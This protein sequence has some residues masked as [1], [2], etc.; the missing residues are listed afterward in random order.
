MRL[1][2]LAR[3]W[4]AIAALC[5]I[6]TVGIGQ[7]SPRNSFSKKE[8]GV[9]F[10]LHPGILEV[11]VCS[12]SM[13]H[14]L[15]ILQEPVPPPTVP[16]IIDKDRSNP[17]PFKIVEGNGIVSVSTA[18]LTVAVELANGRITFLDRNDSVILQE[19]DSSGKTLAPAV[20]GGETLWRPEQKFLSPPDEAFY[21]L[22]Q[23][24]EGFF[25]WR[26]IPL[27]LQ[28]VD[29]NI[30]M[31]FVLSSKGYGLLWNSA[32]LTDFNP[33]DEV[34]QIDSVTKS[35]KFRS[36]ESGVYGFM[37]TGG[38]GREH[39]GL[40]V[41]GE[42]VVALDGYLVPYSGSGILNLQPNTDYTLTME[43]ASEGAKVYVRPPSDTTGFRSEVGKTIDY[44]FFYGPNLNEVIKQYRD[45]TGVAPMFP[46]WAYGFWQCRE[47][48]SSQDQLL[49]AAAG[50]RQ[51]HIPVDV[52]VQDWQYWGKFGWNAMKFDPD[53]YP[54]PAGMIHT[55][56]SENLHFAISVW[57][58]FDSQTDIYKQMKARSLLVPGSEWFDAF[59]PQ[60]R[61]LFWSSMRE[62]LFQLGVDGWWLDAT[63]PEG[64]ILKNNQTFMGP[65]NALRNAYPLYVT[66]AVFQGQRETAAA[67]RVVILTRSAFP[68][69][70]RNAT[71]VWSGDIAGDWETF[72]RQVSAGLNFT[73]TG[74]PYWTT[75][76]GGFNRPTDQ[77]KS[78]AYHEL[79]T[80]WFEYGI[81]C[82][83]FRIHGDQSETEIWNY[84][85]DVE[86]TFRK[87]DVFHYRLLPYIYSSAWMITSQGTT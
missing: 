73:M 79:L 51:R 28:Q 16:I 86:D 71:A 11:R 65:G 8:D 1:N 3:S 33:T 43:G 12:E 49:K 17:V 34:V 81:F 53:H 27:R 38:T 20:V 52:M 26:G 7:D 41:N 64:D 30:A 48:Y 55:L 74:M 36:V 13:V 59:N 32:A 37:V 56:H 67:K 39:L 24:Q 57:S 76:V 25:N 68:G 54:N 44:Y 35:G 42:S 4:L 77:Y 2:R 50:F 23:H 6:S 82:P 15:Y 9:L 61:A 62:R 21:G 5:C 31:P 87:F 66:R 22:G 78:P 85:A 47:R 14:I 70:Q 46:K 69:Q 58:K 19:P 60:A 84:G 29:A 40:R 72:R 18:K 45:A 83:L 63:E 10:T 75:D 80:R